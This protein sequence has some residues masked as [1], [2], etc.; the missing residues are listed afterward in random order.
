MGCTMNKPSSLNDLHQT[1]I[2][3]LKEKNRSHSTI[4]AYG[5]DISQLLELVKKRGKTEASDIAAEDVE[6]FKQG[7]SENGYN[8]KSIARKI[9]SIKSFFNFCQEKGWLKINPAL[10]IKPPKYQ[11]P[12]PRVLSKMEYRALRD[13]A[14]HDARLEAIIE[15]LLQTGMRIGEL[16]RL[17]LGNL[18][19]NK[20]ELVIE[21]YQSQASRTIPL[22]LAAQKAIKTYLQKRPPS[23]NNHLFLTKTGRPYLVRNIR[24][25]INRCFKEAGIKEVKVGDLRHTFIVHQLQAGVP[26]TTISQIAGHKRL[27]TTEK[28]L[29]FLQNEPSKKVDLEEL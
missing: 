18:N 27:S 4:L 23:K 10:N 12:Q 6:A 21:T 3:H 13:A 29:E 14:R 25:A 16:S 1:F 22:N 19:F 17:Q 15:L 7:F 5:K 9:N 2:T 20:D 24:S 8:P 26:L 11:N 28:Y